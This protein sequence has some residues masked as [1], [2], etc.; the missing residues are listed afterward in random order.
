[1]TRSI[2]RTSIDAY[3]KILDSGRLA[4]SRAEVLRYFVR[5]H[6]ET[7]T[8]K[9]SDKQINGDAHKRLSELRDRGLLVVL[10]TRKCRVCKKSDVKEWGLLNNPI[11]RNPPPSKKIILETVVVS[12]CSECVMRSENNTCLGADEVVNCPKTGRSC[13]C[14]LFEKTYVIRGA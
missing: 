9:E 8:G 4:G 12:N 7:L 2:E 14:P 6:P 5:I 11:L 3:L 13:D 10:G 1:M